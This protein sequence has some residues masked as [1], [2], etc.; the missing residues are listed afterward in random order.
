VSL[1][2]AERG[3]IALRDRRYEALADYYR[4][5]AALERAA[6]GPLSKVMRAPQPDTACTRR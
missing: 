5:R 6:G 1:V 4:R 3:L 2:E